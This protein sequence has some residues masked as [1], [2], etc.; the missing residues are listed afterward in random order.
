MKTVYIITC[1]HEKDITLEQAV[2]D[3][4]ERGESPFNAYLFHSPI[5]NLFD[6][7]DLKNSIIAGNAW[8][9]KADL[10]VTYC[11]KMGECSTVKSYQEIYGDRLGQRSILKICHNPSCDRKELLAA[12]TAYLMG[13][14]S[15]NYFWYC[16]KCATRVLLDTGKLLS[17]S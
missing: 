8:E 1:S 14:K 10:I 12:R 15:L 16:P 2:L 6:E 5:L 13:W 4:L 7:K 17:E 11:P 3:C 9:E